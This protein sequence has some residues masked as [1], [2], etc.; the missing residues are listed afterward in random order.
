MWLKLSSYVTLTREETAFLAELERTVCRQPARADLLRQGDRYGEASVLR[1][2]W[3][4]R[5]KALPDGRRQVINFVLPGD[6]IGTYS[7]LFECA[8]HSVSTLTAAEVASFP[9][10]RIV[11]LFQGFPR[12]A[13]AL[14]WAGAR[15]EAMVAERLLSLGRRT[16]LERVAHLI[17]ELLRRL[18]VVNMAEGGNFTLPVTQEIM[19]DALGLSIVHVNRTLRRLRDSGLIEV[20]GQRITVKDVQQ[21]AVVG[22]FDELYLHLIQAPDQLERAFKARG[23]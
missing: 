16:A 17:V 12:L 10:E 20:T 21:L 5:H 6:I 23:A 14:A 3:A 7:N 9:P 22:Q 13:A 18:S 8:D 4:I 2:G 1:D 19:A 15:E 11:E